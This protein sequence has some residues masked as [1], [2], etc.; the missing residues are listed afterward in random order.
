MRDYTKHIFY[1]SNMI[2]VFGM[3][4]VL[5]LTGCSHGMVKHQYIKNYTLGEI[6]TAYIGQPIIKIRDIYREVND[7]E[8]N[9]NNKNTCFYVTP[10][11]D[12]SI[13]GIYTK[14]LFNKK[15]DIKGSNH[16]YYP[17]N[18]TMILNGVVYSVFD[19][20]DNTGTIY[21][22]M[23]DSN[24]KIIVK[25][26]YYENHDHSSLYNLRNAVLS[27]ENTTMIVSD[28]KATCYGFVDYDNDYH[29]FVVGNNNYELIYGG[30]NNVSIS[31]TYRE[32]TRDNL[33]R[34]SFFQNLI[35]ETSAKEIRFK[36]FKVVVIDST[37]EKITYK[38]IEDKLEDVVFRQNGKEIESLEKAEMENIK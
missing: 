22:L 9:N 1:G 3:L 21:G 33:A 25:F 35:Y 10:S 7:R 13:S 2:N 30:I 12:F 19:I 8:V 15:L 37:N 14:K 32:F 16:K 20:D 36:N 31:I 38:I 24:N 26:V 18:D 34:P 17:L 5:A 23:L 29:N 28:K 27:P 4:I 11:N 6:Q